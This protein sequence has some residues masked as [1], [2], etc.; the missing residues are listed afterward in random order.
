MAPPSGSSPKSTEGAVRFHQWLQWLLER[1]LAAAAKEIP[2]VQD[3]PV[4]FD[5]GGADAWAWQH[6]L[7]KDC[8]IG[9]PPDAFNRAGRIGRCRRWCRTASARGGDQPMVQTLRAVLRH[10]GGLRI[11]HVMGLFRLYLDSAG[12]RP[13]ARGL[14]PLPWQTS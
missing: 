4:G 1:Q 14:R 13:A 2:L 8:T 6:L 7:A 11:D 5:P 3:L 10:A 9:A 12:A